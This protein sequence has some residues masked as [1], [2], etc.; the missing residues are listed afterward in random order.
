MS[1][2][3]PPEDRYP[4]QTYVMEYNDEIIKDA[5]IRELARGGRV[6]LY[7]RVRTIDI[8]GSQIQELVPDARID[9]AHGQNGRK[10]A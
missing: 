8:K 9:C 7:N 1:L 6:Y 3:E 5:I 4:V 2:K 10:K